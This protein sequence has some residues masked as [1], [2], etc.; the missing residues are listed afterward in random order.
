MQPKHVK[1]LKNKKTID[2][3][4]EANLMKEPMSA[5]FFF[6]IDCGFFDQNLK[7][8]QKA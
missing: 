4:L 8:K 2:T 1:H 3:S 7:H 6:E 5:L